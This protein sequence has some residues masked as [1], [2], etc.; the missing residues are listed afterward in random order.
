M[1]A[2]GFF[3]LNLA[4][5]F[6]NAGTI[7]A[8]EADIFRTWRLIGPKYF[9]HVQRLHWRKMPYWV[10]LPIGL[11]I[12]GAVALI[13]FHPAHSPVWGIWGSLL[14][15]LVSL[16]LTVFFWGRWQNLLARDHRGSESP[17]LQKILETH[18]VRTFLVNANALILL[19][20][21]FWLSA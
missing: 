2:T 11:G 19:L 14:C 18:W 10:F 16:V 15:Q 8:H 13:W 5:G 9:G 3:L 1:N 7:W 4:L 12:L 20:W 17:Y 21:S 6:Y